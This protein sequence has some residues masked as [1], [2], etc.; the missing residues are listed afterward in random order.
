MYSDLCHSQ[1]LGWCLLGSVFNG[2][3]SMCVCLSGIMCIELLPIL[4]HT[5]PRHGDSWQPH[6]P[7]TPTPFWGVSQTQNL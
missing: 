2:M 4:H 6:F 7:N 1:G 3:H 5:R